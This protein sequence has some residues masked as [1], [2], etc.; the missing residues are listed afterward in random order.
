MHRT[1]LEDVR[2][3]VCTI[4]RRLVRLAVMVNAVTLVE[5]GVLILAPGLDV[6][7]VQQLVL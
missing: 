2:L 6:L 7:V 5:A 3:L 4:A 1:V